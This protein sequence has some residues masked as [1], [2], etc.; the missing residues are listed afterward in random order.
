ML[1][2]TI[3]KT[4]VCFVFLFSIGFDGVSLL[5]GISLSSE[6][7]AGVAITRTTGSLVS[8]NMH[9]GMLIRTVLHNL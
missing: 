3:Q 4:G 7:N 8:Q 5:S 2:T 1:Q 6:L 9:I